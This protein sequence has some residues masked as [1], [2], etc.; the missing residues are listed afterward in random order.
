MGQPGLARGRALRRPRELPLTRLE[1]SETCPAGVALDGQDR[2]GSAGARM[3]PEE[4][5]RRPDRGLHRGLDRGRAGVAPARGGGLHRSEHDAEAPAAGEADLPDPGVLLALLQ[6]LAE[7]RDALVDIRIAQPR[8]IAADVS[9]VRRGRPGA[10]RPRSEA[11]DRDEQR[12]DG[13]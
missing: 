11:N 13:E 9:L 4:Q 10:G 2:L 12:G 7:K 8:E 1:S 6:A 5:A 3:R